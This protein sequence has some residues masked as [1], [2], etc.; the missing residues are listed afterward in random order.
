GS[1]V[2][3]ETGFFE[4]EGDNVNVIVMLPDVDEPVIASG[5]I[6]GTED[7]NKGQGVTLTTTTA[8]NT[9]SVMFAVHESPTSDLFGPTSYAEFVTGE[10]SRK[11]VI[12]RTFIALGE[13]ER[14]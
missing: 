11:T 3:D 4:S 13:G 10:P 12:F 5:N 8:L 7:G 9:C 14:G 1:C 2:G 6:K